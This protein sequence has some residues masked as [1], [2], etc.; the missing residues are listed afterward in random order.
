M[1]SQVE[2]SGNKRSKQASVKK[3]LELVG[4]IYG[5]SLSGCRPHGCSGKNYGR[6][7]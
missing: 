1:R 6:F 3:L 2:S 4:A 5:T 7:H